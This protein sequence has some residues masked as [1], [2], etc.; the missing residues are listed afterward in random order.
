[1]AMTNFEE[2]IDRI[3]EAAVEP[4]NWENVLTDLARTAG[5]EG[6]AIVT[7]REGQ[8]RWT[9][10]RVS[11]N[12]QR[13]LEE[14]LRSP[15]AKDS[16]TTVRLLAAKKCGF[17]AD[18]EFFTPEEFASDFWTSEW[19]VKNNV[20]HCTATAV[21]V[22]NGDL[23]VVQLMRRI[24]LPGFNRTELN[25]L[26][27]FRPHLARAGFL[28]ARWRLE[29]VRAAAE[30]LDLIGLPAAILDVNGRVLA[31][32]SLIQELNNHVR[33]LPRNEV[34]L[35]DHSANVLLRNAIRELTNPC[36]TV[37]RSFPVGRRS[38]KPIVVHLI[39]ATMSARELFNGG[40][41]VLAVTPITAPEP[42][43]AALIQGL[44]DL[45]P[46]EAR[47]AGGIVAGM[48]IKEMAACHA[49]GI[50]T[51][52]SQMKSVLSKIGVRRQSE[53]ATRLAVLSPATR[54]RGP[55]EQRF[56]NRTQ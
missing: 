10:S 37:V 44:F 5:G 51:V 3:Y 7:R 27:S 43:D 22:P 20:Y 18:E 14:C 45:T 31:A 4:E 23:V 21:H 54:R 55:A 34:A 32:N 42:P 11:R 28:A 16:L 12:L 13:N 35:K 49:V 1:V 30:A 48:T 56:C 39:P 6:G 15:L 40:F 9:G 53:A 47:V 8:D 46:A 25:L 29:R 24:G 52:R 38:V 41:G 50:E 2:L 17:V 26:D 33:W 36:A 19:A